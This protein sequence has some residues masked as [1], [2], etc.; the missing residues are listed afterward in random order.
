MVREKEGLSSEHEHLKRRT[1]TIMAN[2]EQEKQVS[3]H[4][5]G[6]N[7]F[8]YMLFKLLYRKHFQQR[9][10]WLSTGVILWS[11]AMV[12]YV[13][14]F[15]QC[16]VNELSQQLSQQAEYCFSMGAACCTLLWRVSRHEDCIHSILSGVSHPYKEKNACNRGL[17]SVTISM[18]LPSF[19][20]SD[21]LVT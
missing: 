1:E 14:V 18:Y 7:V 6:I 5:F 8:I 20:W 17:F 21:R 4:V 15:P 9:W 12:C 3:I 2:Y 10:V 13:V 11:G 19:P 16:E